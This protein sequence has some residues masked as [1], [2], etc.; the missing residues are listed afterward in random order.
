MFVRPA[1]TVLRR[2]MKGHVRSIK[3]Y[4][5]YAQFNTND[6]IH[7]PVA[8]VSEVEEEAPQGLTKWDLG[9]CGYNRPCA[10]Q[11]VGKYQSCML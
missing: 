11:Y 6:P 5:S 8:G 3:Y 1:D 9:A 2:E 4:R 10:H 7:Y